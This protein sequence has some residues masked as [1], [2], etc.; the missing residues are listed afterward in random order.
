[1][2]SEKMIMSNFLHTADLF[3]QTICKN[4]GIKLEY[5]EIEN[6]TYKQYDEGLRELF[7]HHSNYQELLK[8]ALHS[9]KP[10]T[11]YRFKDEFLSK[12]IVFIHPDFTPDTIVIIGPYRTE[13]VNLKELYEHA[14]AL[15]LH[16][17]SYP[18]F[19]TI[20]KNIPWISNETSLLTIA[21]SYGEIIWNGLEHFTI[22]QIDR[23][24]LSLLRTD[25][26]LLVDKTDSQVSY[27]KES[28][29]FYLIENQLL[30]AVTRGNAHVAELQL[31]KLKKQFNRK[32]LTSTLEES[33]NYAHIL[34]A[35]FRKATEIAGV[36]PYFINELAESF[37]QQIELLSSISKI[38]ILQQDLITKYCDLVTNIS[39][40][41]YSPL[42]RNIVSYINMDLTNDLSL[43]AL[44]DVFHV[45]R[46]YLSSLFHENTGVTLTEYVQRQ[47]MKHG[48]FLMQNTTLP[49]NAIAQSCGIVDSNY[50]SRLF[51]KYY[52]VNPTAYRSNK[53]KLPSNKFQ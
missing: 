2:E 6:P 11:L 43:T 47:R 25:T 19:K 26:H 37:S 29:T 34:N 53:L 17:A 33:K 14:A 21:T 8:E 13:E 39:T 12:Y 52:S 35:L 32:H 46:K 38:P 41:D 27:L 31:E 20:Y 18:M 5:I 16:P 36:P 50:F 22:E 48:L 28:E 45:D 51:K 49:I 7:Y 30:E 24:D 44:A 15:S 1:M 10:N 40:A 42:I 3:F 9:F 23:K 4:Y